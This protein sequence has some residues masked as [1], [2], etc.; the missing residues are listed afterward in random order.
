MMTNFNKKM[1][2]EIRKILPN[3]IAEELVG[4]QPMDSNI[5]KTM[6]ENSVDESELIKNGFEPIDN[7]TKLIWVKKDD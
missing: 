4:V 1:L 5:I 7:N 2:D 3:K 6:Y